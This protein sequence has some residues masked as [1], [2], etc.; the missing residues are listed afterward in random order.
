MLTSP[1]AGTRNVG[2]T[3]TCEYYKLP[4]AGL[5]PAIHVF[6]LAQKDVGARITSGHGVNDFSGRAHSM[7]SSASASNADGMVRPSAFAVFRLMASSNLVGCSTGKSPGLAPF[8]I[9]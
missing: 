8:R 4:L 6:D 9:L 7:T 2:S 1:L 5:D 3:Y